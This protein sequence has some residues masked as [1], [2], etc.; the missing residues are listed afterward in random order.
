MQVDT[1]YVQPGIVYMVSDLALGLHLKNMPKLRRQL[2][3]SSISGGTRHYA[4]SVYAVGLHLLQKAKQ[5]CLLS[6]ANRFSA[7]YCK[8]FPDRAICGM[9]SFVGNGGGKQMQLMGYI[10]IIGCILGKY[11]ILGI[12]WDNGKDNGCYYMIIGYVYILS[13]HKG[14][15][16]PEEER[17]YPRH[18][19]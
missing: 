6:E 14:E 5:V 10:G 4:L 16:D 2:F 13:K 17:L 7:I 19:A 9:G 1:E 12:Y 8:P 18:L 15:R 3:S 11:T